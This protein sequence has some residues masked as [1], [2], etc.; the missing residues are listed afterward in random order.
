MGERTS[1]E[2]G[3]FSWVDLATSDAAAAQSFYGGLFGWE[4]EDTDAG[5]G[6]VYT[7]CRVG[8]D[9]V[10]GLME[11]TPEMRARGVPPSWTSYVTV[12]DA[13]AVLEHARQLGGAV[14]ADAF[15]VREAGRMAVLADPQGAVFAV[16]QPRASIGA[17]RVNDIGCL[18]MNE[19]ATPDLGA[20]DAFYA[21]LF[22]WR[23]EV[24][25]PGPGEPPMALIYRGDALNASAGVA[26]PGEPAH[27]RPYFTVEAVDGAVARTRELGGQVL[28]EPIAIP[29]GR[30]AIAA[31]PQ[32]AVFAFFEGEV[33]P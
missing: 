17:E 3:T 27:W 32:G 5:D 4:L 20:A 19:L 9:I 13:D 29:D 11:M 6:A 8:E 28:L 31:D 10:C 26:Q 33:D 2:P 16:W 15:D 1:Y 24:S 21:G 18:C 12:S 14:L 23:M 7:L 25:E 22:G 30:I